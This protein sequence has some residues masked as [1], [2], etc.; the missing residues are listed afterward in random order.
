MSWLTP[1]NAELSPKR[2][3]RGPR[4]QEAGEEGYIYIYPTLHYH[5][6]NDSCIKTGSNESH[7]KA[8]FSVRGKVTKAVSADHNI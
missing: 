7:F 8:S 1:V 3:W 6:Q 5:H 2:Y 4:S